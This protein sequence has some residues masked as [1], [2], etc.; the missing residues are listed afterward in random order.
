MIKFLFKGL[1]SDR[2][3]SLLPA[4]V[5]SIGV[6]LTV[7]LTTFMN[8]YM[9]DSIE[10][11]ANFYF[12]H[13]K[14]MTKAFAKNAD[15]IPNDLALTGVNDLNK[16]LRS[17]YNNFNWVER[18]RFFGLMDFPD[19]NGETRA[20]GPAVG[21]AANILSKSSGEIERLNIGKSIIKGKIPSKMGEALISDD[22][23]S[24]Y[25]IKIGD[26]FTLFGSSMDGSMSF[27]NFTVSG[28]VK[29]GSSALDK[30]ALIID[31][32]DARR[33]FKMEDA[34]SEILG[35]QKQGAFEYTKVKSILTDFNNKYKNS[36]DEY[37]PL[38]LSLR[39]QSGM[40]ELLDYT[41]TVVGMFIV[42]FVI[43]MSIVLW[44]AGLLGGLRRYKEF[45][46]RLALGEEK[47]HIYKTII[48]EGILIGTIGTIAGT[49]IG[50]SLSFYLQSYGVNISGLMKNS[51][52]LF[53]S[54]LKANVTIAAFFI[55]FI[56]GLFSTVLG[57]ALSG[58]VIY[59]RQTARLFNELEV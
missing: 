12:G 46:I 29:F 59:K 5:V 50:L 24:R 21:W 34:A 20:Q 47:S 31:I 17:T 38:M 27:Y 4:I 49:L 26:E 25:K 3:R 35:F 33:A 36:T 32:S 58:I 53:P 42:I 55:G 10:I 9:S 22:F 6:F 56:P 57:N 19:K 18:I 1:I 23:A 48:Y 13:V 51:S 40:G 14:I 41:N 2:N 37:A 7:V 28:I 45:G 30:G 39:D 44:N 43:A 8:G 11:N 54:V 52:M 15:Q 16:T